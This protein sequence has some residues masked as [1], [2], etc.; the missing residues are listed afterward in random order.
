MGE[1]N[2]YWALMPKRH[3]FHTDKPTTPL[4]KD[5]ITRMKQHHVLCDSDTLACL[6]FLKLGRLFM[7]TDNFL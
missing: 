5:A 4:A 6:R 1:R 7:E 3:L 2:T